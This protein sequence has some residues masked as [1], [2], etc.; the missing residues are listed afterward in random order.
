MKV[1]VII[2]CILLALAILLGA[3]VAVILYK[4]YMLKQRLKELQKN[5]DIGFF[6]QY[7][8]EARTA[9]KEELQKK[10]N[11]TFEKDIVC[12]Y[13]IYLNKPTQFEG[14][15]DEKAFILIFESEDDASSLATN[16]TKLAED[17]DMFSSSIDGHIVFF[18]ERYLLQFFIQI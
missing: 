7:H 8:K 2:L 3:A 13:E 18:G 12:A 4:P 17:Y 14:Q 6:D 16:A 5:G 11:I 15:V 10:L 1:F 9:L